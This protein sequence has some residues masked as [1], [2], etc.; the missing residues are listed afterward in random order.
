[1]QKCQDV[2]IAEV[3]KKN[4]ALGF[5]SV[6]SPSFAKCSVT[7][8][9]PL[10]QVILLVR[11]TATNRLEFSQLRIAIVKANISQSDGA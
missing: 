4:I 9:H 1:M 2:T 7:A 10:F 11:A 6:I 8:L 5:E 3:E